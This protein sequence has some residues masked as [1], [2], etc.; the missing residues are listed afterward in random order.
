MQKKLFILLGLFLPMSIYAQLIKGHIQDDKTKEA[1]TG[2]TIQVK[3]TNKGTRSDGNGNY[4][5]NASANELLVITYLGYNK[6][7]IKVGNST[8]I[9]VNL[10]RNDG[11][12]MKAVTIVGSRKPGRTNTESAAPIDVIDMSTTTK[13]SGKMDVNQMLQFAAPSFNANKQSGSDGADHIDPASLRGLG[14]DQT[15]VLI[16]GKRRHQSSLINLFGTRGRG[17]TGTDL[18]TIPAAAIERIE[19]LRDG[20][21]AQYGSDAIAG[22][23]NVV[24]KRNTGELTG[25]LNYGV[26]QT[27][28][29]NPSKDFDG[30]TYQANLNY[31]FDLG[32]DGFINLTG[33]LL[34]SAKTNRIP[35]NNTVTYRNQFGDGSSLNGALWLNG[36][37][38]L[39]KSTDIYFF[40][41]YNSRFSDAYAWTRS[42]TTGVDDINDTI[43]ALHPEVPNDR[44][45]AILYPNGFDPKIQAKIKDASISVGL[46][47]QYKHWMLDLNNT[48]GRN[49]FHYYNDHTLNASLGSASPTSFDAGGFSFAQNTTS[50]NASRSFDILSGLNLAAGVEYRMDQYKIVA[51]EEGSWK[52]Y[53]QNYRVDTFVNSNT[54]QVVELDTVYS[55][56]G[57]QGFPGF[58]PKS[59]VDANR[60]NVGAYVDAELDV[61]KNWLVGGAVRFENYSDFGATLNGKLSTRYRINSMINLRAS[62]SSGFRAPSLQQIYFNTIYTNFEGGVPIEIQLANNT[63]VLAQKIGIPELKQEKSYN[64]SAGLTFR[65]IHPLSLT[66]DA[67]IVKVIDRIILT[68]TF[69]NDDNVVGPDLQAL[70]VGAVNFFTNAVNTTNQGLDIVLA[71]NKRVGKGKLTTSLAANF[72]TLTVDKVNTTDKL[73]GKEDIY[74]SKREKAFLVASAPKSKLNFS[75]TYDWN[76]FTG[77]FRVVRYGE[78]TLLGYD[79]AVQLY[80]AKMVADLALGY[81]INKHFTVNAGIDNLLDVYPDK[82]DIENTESGGAWDPVQMNYN[83]R[84]FFVRLG[85]N[86]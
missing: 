7:E 85:F 51:G 61:N 56:G 58:Q 47:H 19:I 36:E 53:L 3:G 5:V 18:N 2:A 52:N 82:Q 11:T 16:N 59:E 42:A 55:P 25:N 32:K 75:A 22:V 6:Q 29:L 21:S 72:N 48:F 4:A 54:N 35:K 70:N 81:A 43:V 68:G 57:A 20:A 28:G 64:Y 44:S 63:S 10:V 26:Y 46:K 30:Q 41:G 71:Y 78:V 12:E 83:G 84:R 33:D 45:N 80:T 86:L 1:L 62:V 74:F 40:G 39:N 31:G 65:P 60:S 8:T 73:K 15:L 69:Y 38:S 34:S 24:L 14:P 13:Q 77:T 37:K 50:L 67:Y 79:D 66:V 27:N 49:A 9:D 23:M 76:K 17:N